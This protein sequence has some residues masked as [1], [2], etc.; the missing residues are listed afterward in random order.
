MKKFNEKNRKKS[1]N[2]NEKGQELLSI[3][4]LIDDEDETEKNNI[5]SKTSF[6]TGN[7]NI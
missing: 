3:D 4:Y 7:K 2:E 1:N 5:K 6:V